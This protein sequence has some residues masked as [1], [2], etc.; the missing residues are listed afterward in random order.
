MLKKIILLSLIFTCSFYGDELKIDNSELQNSNELLP[1]EK[2]Q[3][4]LLAKIT[5]TIKDAA[6]TVNKNIFLI[7]HHLWENRQKYTLLV[8][9]VTLKVIKKIQ[10]QMLKEMIQDYFYPRK[11]II[12]NPII[13]KY[14]EFSFPKKVVFPER[15]QLPVEP[16]K[17]IGPINL[18]IPFFDFDLD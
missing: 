8:L 1:N 10:K 16:F 13:L 3:I 14:P 17:P 7:S 9:L 2:Q 6:H 18:Q 4:N 12:F 5:T 15:I 11:T